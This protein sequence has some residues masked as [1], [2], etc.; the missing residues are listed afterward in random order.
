MMGGDIT[1]ESEPGQGTVFAIRLPAEV[2]EAG[3]TSLPET[4]PATVLAG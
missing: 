2:R 4:A 1:V 3:E